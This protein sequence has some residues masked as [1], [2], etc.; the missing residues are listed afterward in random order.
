VTPPRPRHRHWRRR[1]GHSIKARLV[2]LFLLLALG[3]TAV[4]LFGM[5][6]VLQNGWL[7]YARPLVTDYADRLA[8]D[9]G[10]PPDPARARA[11]AERLPIS[12]TIAGPRVQFE[13][14]PAARR[15]PRD[16]DPDT[17]SHDDIAAAW[18]LVRQTSD[19]HRI[20][21]G[22]ARVPD[23]SRPRVLGWTTLAALLLLT[24]AAFAAVR[25]LLAP[26]RAIGAGV[27][28]YG[29]GDFSRPIPI[30]RRDELG[31][32][33]E[34]V[35]GM[36]ANLSGMLQ[37]Q[38]ALLLALSH[39]LRSPLTRARVN[40]ELVADG[41]ERD[42]LLRDLGEMRD[43]ITSLLET[44]RLAQGPGALQAQA[45]DLAA[46]VRDF[47][48][49]MPEPAAL[50]LRL[51]DTLAPV[52]AD[53]ARLQLLLRNLVDNALRH[54]AG[55]APPELFVRREDDGRVALGVRDH[56]PG[57]LPAHLAQLG[58]PFWRPDGARSRAHGGVGLGLYLCRRVAQA[59]GGE[60]RLRNAGPGL[61]VA[62]VWTPQAGENPRLAPPAPQP[63]N[64]P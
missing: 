47:V 13:S 30:V 41:P 31:L 63:S 1:F 28:A 61:E 3:T 59:H 34:R 38:R 11:L 15:H 46:L 43:L 36:A 49:A 52:H 53:P 9:I 45:V 4:F 8:A 25:R 62:A 16:D 18:G 64:P 20:D 55:G 12:I 51:D 26:L 14:R 7:A 57:V 27:Q 10:V 33:T 39:E 23:A 40:A 58:Q 21:F 17:P 19:G 32:L 29:Q 2:A 35:N 44:E 48:A 42:A 60:L 50:T 54:G 22:L 6:R 5:Q 37:A 56:G 24:A